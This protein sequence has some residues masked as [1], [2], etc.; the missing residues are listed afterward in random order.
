MD[1]TDHWKSVHLLFVALLEV[2]KL[3]IM[4]ELGTEHWVLVMSYELEEAISSLNVLG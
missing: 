2:S 3:G 1:L 4:V